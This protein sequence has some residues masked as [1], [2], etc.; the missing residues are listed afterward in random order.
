VFHFFQTM[1]K[2]GSRCS[3]RMIQPIN[4]MDHIDDFLS[5]TKRCTFAIYSYHI[6]ER[7]IMLIP[8]SSK[9]HRDR[10]VEKCTKWADTW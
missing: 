4:Y 3:M 8:C 6:T 9:I 10:N 2:K 1:K 7:I 5:K